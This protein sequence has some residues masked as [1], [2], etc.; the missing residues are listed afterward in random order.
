MATDR[1][2]T[3]RRRLVVAV[4][5]AGLLGATALV[6][7]AAQADIDGGR[8]VHRAR[9]GGTVAAWGSTGPTEYAT[10]QGWPYT[11]ILSHYYGGT[12]QSTEP[13]TPITVNLTNQAGTDLVV[14]SDQTFTVGGQA[15]G[16]GSAARIQARS[17]GTFLLSTS[18]GCAQSN[19]LVDDDHRLERGPLGRARQRPPRDAQHLHP[20]RHVAVPR[21]AVGRLGR[22]CAAHRQQGADGG[23][24]PR[25][26]PP[27]VAGQLG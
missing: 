14:T 25:R 6:A 12:T 10:N 8:A 16:G 9:V 11:Q 17:D 19:G 21:G 22:R 2:K 7:P 15:V 5:S 23:L 27:R 18:Y 24:P 4:A 1:R 26:R 3:L 20:Q 13:D